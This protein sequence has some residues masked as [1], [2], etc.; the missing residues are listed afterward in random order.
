VV[1]SPFPSPAPTSPTRSLNGNA[2]SFIPSKN[3]VTVTTQDG[4]R[5]NLQALRRGSLSP[6]G[7]YL[8][9]EV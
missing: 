4:G 2:N 9:F 5:V 7:M 1:S 6:T 3:T 8:S